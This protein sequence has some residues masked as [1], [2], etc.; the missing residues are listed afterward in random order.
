MCVSL[1][2]AAQ[3]PLSKKVERGKGIPPGAGQRPQPVVD[4][5]NSPSSLRDTAALGATRGNK[6][7]KN[8]RRDT[9]AP[10]VLETALF[11]TLTKHER[12]F[13]WRHNRYQNSLHLAPLDTSAGA[14]RTDYPFLQHDAGADY[15]G[16]IGSPVVLHDYFKRQTNASFYYLNPYLEYAITPDNILFY[17]TKTAYTRFQYSGTLFGNSMF[18]E[19]NVSILVSANALPQ[20][21]WAVQYRH[22]G[23]RGYMKNGATDNSAFTLS[24]SYS[25]ARYNA[26]AGFIY[27]GWNNKENGGITNDKL[28]L[29][30]IVDTRT[31]PVSLNAAASKINQYTFFLTHSYSVPLNVF[32]KDSLQDDDGTVIYFGHAAEYTTIERTY[33]DQ[34]PADDSVGRAYYRDAF[35]IHPTNSRDSM[36]TA[37]FD[38]KLFF[39]FQPWA[40]SAIISKVGGG[41][42]YSHLSNYGYRPEFYL[43]PRVDNFTQDNL[44]LYGNASGLFRHYFKWSAFTRYDFAGYTQHDFLLDGTVGISLYPLKKGVH[45]TGNITFQSR[46]PDYFLDNTYANHF[47]WSN[48]FDKTTETKLQAKLTIPDWQLEAS[49][50]YS[51]LSGAVYFN[52]DAQ[53]VQ[54]TGEISVLGGYLKKDVKWWL[55]HFD[56][57]VLFQYSSNPD[58]LPLPLVSA[59]LTYYLQGVVVKNVLTAQ[60]GVDAYYN[61]PYHAY[62]YNPGAGAFHTYTQTE[63]EVGGYPYLDAFVHLKWKHA[64]IFLKM[65][66]VAERWPHSDFFSA[67]HYLRPERTFKLGITW[68]FY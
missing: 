32:R 24:T 10:R 36:R 20:W 30:T 68:Y 13:A 17:N 65:I 38:N 41:V 4:G 55:L 5:Q 23:T 53:P 34:L 59:N 18:E 26:Q 58:I 40:D 63:S 35:F 64:H 29:D 49:F 52:N 62:A 9:S 27:N 6:S 22:F 46:R 48:H 50:G 56:H 8:S 28:V 7:D 43:S 15:L 11:D 2:T 21:N 3:V 67:L 37:L 60:I 1:H 25:G 45:L 57:R 51:L 31:L 61:T 42:G 44:Y 12:I 39:N 14:Y 47:Q 54:H 66:N 19:G 33:T 16:T